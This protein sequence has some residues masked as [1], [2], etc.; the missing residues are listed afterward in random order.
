M[1]S[2]PTTLSAV[3][4]T[5][6]TAKFACKAAKTAH[7]ES[8][9]LGVRTVKSFW[10]SVRKFSKKLSLPSVL[11]LADGTRVLMEEQK[12][13]ALAAEFSKNFNREDSVDLSLDDSILL[14][15]WICREEEVLDYIRLLENTIAVGLDDISPMKNCC[16]ELALAIAAL[17]NKSLQNSRVSSRFQTC[18]DCRYPESPWDDESFGNAANLNSTCPSQNP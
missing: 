13:D 7:C 4:R 9:I 6:K 3:R 8:L 14:D 2:N 10:D 15:S 12:V 1:T 5:Q 18:T 11:E 16:M 17:I